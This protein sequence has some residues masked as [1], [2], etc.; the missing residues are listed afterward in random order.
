MH[1]CLLLFRP[2]HLCTG[3]RRGGCLCNWDRGGPPPP[4]FHFHRREASK[5]K[6]GGTGQAN[7]GTA[8]SGRVG[9]LHCGAT[10]DITY[11][12]GTAGICIPAS[13][14]FQRRRTPMLP[15]RD[16]LAQGISAG[17]A[18]DAFSTSLVPLF[19][20]TWPGRLCYQF[21]IHGLRLS[22]ERAM[23]DCLVTVFRA[24]QHA[25]GAGRSVGRVCNAD[26]TSKY[27]RTAR[28]VGRDV[29]QTN[30]EPGGLPVLSRWPETQTG[31]PP[32]W[33]AAG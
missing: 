33:H 18:P 24:G 29:H 27:S 12:R 15:Q 9:R 10:R 20:P 21:D 4:C 1:V 30:P 5:E 6:T 11:L 16:I 32:A 19:K 23:H 17:S 13:S 26:V 31:A 25:V 14:R 8:R 7:V 22:S 3:A 28:G 2:W